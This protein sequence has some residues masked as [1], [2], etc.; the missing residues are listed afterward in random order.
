[1]TKKRKFAFFLTREIL[2]KAHLVGQFKKKLS[3]FLSLLQKRFIEKRIFE[4]KKS[5]TATYP[6]FLS[7]V[8]LPR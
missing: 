8:N 4:E 3:K 2:G 5:N 7:V 6:T 1:M